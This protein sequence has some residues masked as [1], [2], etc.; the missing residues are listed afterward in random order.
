MV[1]GATM[2][3]AVEGEALGDAVGAAVGNEAVGGDI[4]SA[5]GSAFGTMRRPQ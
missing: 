5:A 4:G 2:G 1:Q 3:Y